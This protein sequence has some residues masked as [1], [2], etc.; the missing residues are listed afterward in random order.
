M[1]FF[2]MNRK[3]IAVF[4]VFAFFSLLH[5]SVLPVQA[6]PVSGTT[7]SD[8]DGTNFMEK[9][10]PAPSGHSGKKS[11]L[12]IILG[13]V[14]AGAVAAVLI[15][16]V[17]KTKYDITGEWTMNYSWP[18]GELATYPI[19]FTGDKNSGTAFMNTLSGPYAVAGKK[20]TITMTQNT[21]KWVY[22]GE[23][24]SKIR[25]EGDFKYYINNVLQPQYNGTFYADK[26]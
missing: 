2:N 6:A 10:A 19:T 22:S 26:K 23:F 11:V 20:V 18:G 3:A 17:F 25:M 12:P 15:L 16:V 9:A 7:P 8:N 13:A 4:V 1:K 5:I 24:K 14:A 21:G